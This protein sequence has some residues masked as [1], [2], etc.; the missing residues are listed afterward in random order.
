MQIVY[1]I[2]NGFDLNLGLKTTYQDFYKAYTPSQNNSA[3]IGTFKDAINA[4]IV[5]WSDLEL[6]L[7][8]YTKNLSTVEELD[9]IHESVVDGLANYLS[10]IQDEFINDKLKK[11]DKS[12]FI[13]DLFH[14]E[15]H[16]RGR[17]KSALNDLY[18][19]NG[20]KLR[21]YT[22]INFNYTNTIELIL[23]DDPKSTYNS[24]LNHTKTK[25]N[26]QYQ[27]NSTLHIHGTVDADMVLG[28]NELEQIDNEDLTSNTDVRDLLV[29]SYCNLA[30]RH[31]LEETCKFHLDRANV[32]CIFGSSIGATDQ[33]W[34][35][36]IAR[37][38]R[39]GACSL[40][41]FEYVPSFSYRRSNLQERTRKKTLSKFLNDADIEKFSSRIHFSFNSDMF[42]L[43]K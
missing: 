16:L 20:S 38:L 26:I 31:G 8:C 22:I 35:D 36:L 14:P 37:R 42:N 17:D 39:T 33:Y 1:I 4:D 27:L 6:S 19:Q 12:K 23:G 43:L 21:N 3:A 32:I 15:L 41:I 2:G 40:I 18:R 34:W 13:N 9:S 5:N 25:A 7:G 10:Q 30:M 24:N 11:I 29:K 28:V